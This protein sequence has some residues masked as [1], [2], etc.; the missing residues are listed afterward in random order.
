MME[1]FDIEFVKLKNGIHQFEYQLNKSFFDFFKNQEVNNAII[2]VKAVLNKFDNLLQV[3]IEGTGNIEMTCDRCLSDVSYPV[4]NR[5]KSI[6]HLNSIE[7]KIDEAQEVNLDVYY[8][9]G[10]QFKINISESIYQSFI[11]EIPM[12]K[13]CDDIDG[14]EC[15][16]DML[17]KIDSLEE[18][19]SDKNEIDPRWEELKKL[20]N[21][22]EK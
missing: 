4:E 14:K 2:S 9:S 11:T 12:V 16:P 8:L 18:T 15:N 5:F 22:K 6:Y 13:R 20:L 10:S 3:D 21:N 1:E 7:E 17:D 19:N